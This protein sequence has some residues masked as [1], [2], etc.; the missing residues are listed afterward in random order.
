MENTI[1]KAKEMFLNNVKDFGQDPHGLL[2]HI[3]EQEK[4]IK[5]VMKKF[6]DAQKDILFLSAYLHDIGHYPINKE[7]DHAI[8]SEQKAK[9]FLEQE[10]V[11]ENIRSNV[12]HCVRSHRCNDVMPQTLEAK[13]FACIDSAS[14][15]TDS[16][17]MDIASDDGNSAR[18]LGKLERDYRDVSIFPEIQLLVSDIYTSWKSLLAEY[19]KLHKD[20]D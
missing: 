14:H 17:Y 15:M 3:N 5:I 16:M 20:L 6:P 12:L 11:I 9:K 8:I 2:Y 7:I 4:W 13:L 10:N 1:S 18:A 19:D